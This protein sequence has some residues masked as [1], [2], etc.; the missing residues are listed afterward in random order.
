MYHESR[1]K[2]VIAARLGIMEETAGIIE[3][4]N[5]LNI[6]IVISHC[7]ENLDWIAGYIGGDDEYSIHI[8]DVTIYSKCGKDIEG[9]QILTELTTKVTVVK[10][11]NVGRCD[12]TYA[13][14]IQEHYKSIVDTNMN[15]N[16]DDMVIFLKDNAR[17]QKNF[18]PINLLFSH[19][20][21]TGFGCVSKPQCLLV[22]PRFNICREG[23]FVPIMQHRRDSLWNF[24]LP[25]YNRIARDNSTLFLSEQYPVL[26]YWKEDMGFVTPQS[27]TLPVCYEG[28]FATQKKQ[29]LNQKLK[30]WR[31][32]ERSLSRGNN[33][34]E[35]HY[36]ER[37]WASILSDVDDESARAV[38]DVLSPHIV[39][40]FHSKTR[41][42]ERI[43]GMVGMIY[44]DVY[45][46]QTLK[47][48][49]AANLLK[50]E[51]QV[52]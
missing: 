2:N 40:M 25:Y 13:Y 26:K 19:V 33:I 31:K 6:S 4:V 47:L 11:P 22:P 34:I 46:H 41:L 5:N 3:A 18:L 16:E 50:T 36:A 29:F 35:S 45:I 8:T 30:T 42:A 43:T 20:R 21:E 28:S 10:L 14:W 24:S 32:M 51:K 7:E 39:K 27:E 48:L 17:N 49:Y 12:H 44:I 37:M 15:G 23:S 38:D 1:T 9:I 52:P